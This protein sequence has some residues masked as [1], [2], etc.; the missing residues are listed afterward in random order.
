MMR[1]FTTTNGFLT[2]YERH[3]D[4]VGT[5]TIE[6]TG[7]M[8][9]VMSHVN[10][11]LAELGYEDIDF[12]KSFYGSWIECGSPDYLYTITFTFNL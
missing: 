2:M 9:N 3:E 12:L 6:Y 10:A 1:E 8:G 11:R 7:N 5:L 4:G